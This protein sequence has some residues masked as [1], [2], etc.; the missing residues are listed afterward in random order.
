M[1]MKRAILTLAGGA[2][3]LSA[4]L[5]QAQP[6]CGARTGV[7][8]Q[9]QNKFGEARQG[10]GFGTPTQIFELWASNE[11]GSWTLLMTRADGT[12]CV[13]AAGQNWQDEEPAPVVMG[14]P[15]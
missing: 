7:V 8:T 10:M 1:P 13:V 3:L 12:T 14:S 5:A 6:A 9:L 11:T 2:L 4:P 15:T